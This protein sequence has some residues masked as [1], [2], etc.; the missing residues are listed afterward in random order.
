MSTPA[1]R[2]AVSPAAEEPPASTMPKTKTPTPDPASPAHKSPTPGSPTAAGE[3]SEP[4]GVLGGQYWLQ[5]ELP[6][7][8]LDSTLGS[9]DE[10]ST[11]SLASSIL[12]YRRVNGRTYHSDS[13]TDGEYW[14]PNDAK[15]LDALEVFAHALHLMVGEKLAFAPIGKDI[16][17]AVD[18]GTASGHWAM[19]FADE[20]PNCEVIGTDISPVQPTWCPPNLQFLIDDA[21]K[22]WTFKPDYFDYIHIRFL[23]GAIS[24]WDHLYEQAYRVCKPGGWMEHIDGTCFAGCEDGVLPKGSAL[25]QYG[26]MFEEA[27]RRLG[28]SQRVA[29]NELQETGLKRA[30]FVNVSAKEFKVS[31]FTMSALQKSV[32]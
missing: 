12:H 30:G 25:E 9:D 16:K 28:L 15:H 18:I 29:D 8:D 31:R 1:K 13:V 17:H 14:L 27:G 32:N 3:P 5:Q 6:E 2:K 7:N 23:N 19:D 24:D 22:E 10:S 4:T 11:A 26:K 20:Y 21:N